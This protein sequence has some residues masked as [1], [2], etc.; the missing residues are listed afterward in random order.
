MALRLW[1]RPRMLLLLLLLLCEALCPG[2]VYAQVSGFPCAEHEWIPATWHPPQQ[3]ECRSCYECDIG[4]ECRRRGGCFNC[5]AGMYDTDYDPT[6]RCEECPEGKFSEEAATTCTQRSWTES[7]Q[8]S[9]V[10][11][12]VKEDPLGWIQTLMEVTGS[13]VAF[14]ACVCGFW[15]RLGDA[16]GCSQ[17]SDFER[18][19][20]EDPELGRQ[21]SIVVNKVSCCGHGSAEHV[22]IGPANLF[23]SQQ[24]EQEREREL[25]PSTR[26]RGSL[27]RPW[28]CRLCR[29][30]L[31]RSGDEKDQSAGQ[32]IRR[33]TTAGTPGETASL[34]TPR[35]HARS[36]AV[37]P[38][39]EPELEPIPYPRPERVPESESYRPVDSSDPFRSC[40]D[41]PYVQKEI[42]WARQHNKNIIIV[43]E[44]E[45]HRPGF[46]DY[47]RAAAKYTGTEWEFIL[48]IDAIPYQR[49]KYLAG[50]MVEN[51][52]DKADT[53]DVVAAERPINPPGA[54]EFFLSHHQALGGDQMKTLSLLLEE[55]DKTVWYDN[56]KLDKSE[57]AMEE[58]VKH[59]KNF[60]LMLTAKIET[61]SAVSVFPSTV[62]VTSKPIDD[63]P[64]PEP[65]LQP[66][67]AGTAV[68][69]VDG[70]CFHVT[71]QTPPVLVDGLVGTVQLHERLQ[72]IES[73][74]RKNESSFTKS[75][76]IP[77]CLSDASA[78]HI[79]HAQ[80][81]KGQVHC[82]V[83]CG[84]GYGWEESVGDEQPIL[85]VASVVR[86]SPATAPRV[87]VLCLQ[88]GA[89]HA[90]HCLSKAGVPTVI[91]LAVDMMSESF[92]E[93]FAKV[94]APTVQQVEAGHPDA[95]II[96]KGMRA[97]LE[98]V[99]QAS[100]VQK[101]P[102]VC[103]V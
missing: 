59:C 43:F 29:C 67:Q 86:E 48:G 69:T 99:V 54:W 75:N 78:S 77:I 52:L 55:K 46:F 26:E 70:C 90:A 30:P 97:R 73:F 11:Q 31:T 37:E 21:G 102:N 2:V 28:L 71:M 63:E 24:A 58:G 14:I 95:E 98:T 96:K 87:A 88:H 33:D 50:A 83:W 80:L 36:D 101:K 8:P 44:R 4:Q 23:T 79:V 7:L 17:E 32:G 42:R 1:I 51:I 16:C 91:W 60:V 12:H 13:L 84:R 82:L 15:N 57:N 94:I 100:L 9:K 68:S 65:Q 89:R 62:D 64:Q 61:V 3:V 103:S 40:L 10:A 56:G 76:Q 18:T 39:P 22:Q 20:S 34:L 27:T 25:E 85:S 93:V 6:H 81:R 72:S 41:R 5:T 53:A 47:S 92:N 38:E 74:L 66:Q 19:N 35:G 49:D 45:N